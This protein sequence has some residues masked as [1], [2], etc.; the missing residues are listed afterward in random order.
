MKSWFVQWR[1]SGEGEKS[2]CGAS[3]SRFF[4]KFCWKIEHLKWWLAWWTSSFN[5][6][7]LPAAISALF[8]LRTWGR[9]I[10]ERT[11]VMLSCQKMLWRGGVKSRKWRITEQWF[12][13]QP[14]ENYWGKKIIEA[15]ICSHPEGDKE[16]KTAGIC[17]ANFAWAGWDLVLGDSKWIQIKLGITEKFTG[18][19]GDA[20]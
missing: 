14:M 18:N 11:Q 12:Q 4:F 10:S 3:F 17:R 19:F 20:S 13:C 9:G 1:Q 16:E 2:Q 8:T 6:H 5:I 7:T 15:R